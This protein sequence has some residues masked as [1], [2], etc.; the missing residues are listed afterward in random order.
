[1][2]AIL[3]IEVCEPSFRM[4]LKYS[5]IKQKVFTQSLC[6]FGFMTTKSLVWYYIF[7]IT[8]LCIQ[9][10]ILFWVVRFFCRSIYIAYSHTLLSA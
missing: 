10:F 8:Q 7:L 1:M 4:V 6:V 3:D 2:V 9:I 5:L